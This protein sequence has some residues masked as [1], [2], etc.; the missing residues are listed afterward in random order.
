MMLPLKTFFMFV[1]LFSYLTQSF[2]MPPKHTS[3]SIYYVCILKIMPK[4]SANL[5]SIPMVSD[6]DNSTRTDLILKVI[7]N[8]IVENNRIYLNEAL[9]NKFAQLNYNIQEL[10]S[11]TESKFLEMNNNIREM[12]DNIKELRDIISRLTSAAYTVALFVAGALLQLLFSKLLG[13]L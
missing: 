1:A 4:V 5:K 8:E 2:F 12:R 6:F 7:Q 11:E 10:N 3:K 13:K 9:D